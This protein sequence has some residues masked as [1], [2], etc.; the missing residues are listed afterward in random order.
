MGYI[1]GEGL[2]DGGGAIRGVRV[3][4]NSLSLRRM[5]N[6]AVGTDLIINGY[7]S[8]TKIQ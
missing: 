3:A 1:R 2:F 6:Q 5:G 4:G 8:E 7:S